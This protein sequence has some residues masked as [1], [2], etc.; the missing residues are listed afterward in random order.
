MMPTLMNEFIYDIPVEQLPIYRGNHLI[1]RT[2]HPAILPALL[3]EEN[4]D[5]IVGV[6]LLS[7]EADS[8]ALNAWAPGLPLDLVMTDPATEFPLLY[9]HTNLLDNHP[10]RV[11][12]PVSPGFGK[13]VKVAVALDFAVLLEAGQPEPALIE[14]LTEVVTFYLRQ[15]SVTQPVEFFHSTLL[16]FYHDDPMPLWVVVDENPRYQRYVTDAGIECL[17][18]RLANVEVAVAPDAHREHEIEQVLAANE[19]C[20][21]CEFLRSCG[22]YFKWPHRDYDCAGMKRLFGLLQDAAAELR[23]DLDAGPA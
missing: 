5:H 4:P 7:L 10:A 11:V 23:R 18:G 17:P 2:R 1:L 20:Q 22:G 13:A 15:P 3:A 19:D 21:S 8:E 16:G 9:R 6:R 14:E 12:I